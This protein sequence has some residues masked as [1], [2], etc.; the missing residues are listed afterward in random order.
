M[1]S[2]DLEDLRIQLQRRTAEARDTITCY[3][4]LA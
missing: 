2:S 4:G 1:L 3:A